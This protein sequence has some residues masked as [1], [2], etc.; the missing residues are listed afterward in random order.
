[1]NGLQLLPLFV[2]GLAG[3]VHCVGMCGGIVGALLRRRAT[4]G[5]IPVPRGARRRNAPLRCWP[6]TPAASAATCWRAPGRRPGTGRRARWRALPALQL[7]CLLAGQPDAAAARPVPDGCLARPGARWKR[8][9]ADVARVQPLIRRS[10]R[11]DT[12]AESLRPRRAVGLAALRDGLQRAADRNAE[13]L[14]RPRRIG[15]AGLRP[16]HAA[17]AAGAWPAGR[18]RARALRAVACA[19][20]AACWCWASACSASRARRAGCRMAGSMRFAATVQP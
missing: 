12:A 16:G 8:A 4:G 20:P 1:M 7:G 11:C 2:A 17:D 10:C 15:D 19:S 18:A 3:S 14:R 6:I 5:R 13:R 9:A